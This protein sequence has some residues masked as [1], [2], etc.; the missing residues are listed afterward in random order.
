ASPGP[1]GTEIILLSCPTRKQGRPAAAPGRIGPH[2]ADRTAVSPHNDTERA[3]LSARLPIAPFCRGPIQHRRAHSAGHFL[4][5]RKIAPP[6][7][8]GSGRPAPY[9]VFM[10]ASIVGILAVLRRNLLA[11]SPVTVRTVITTVRRPI[12]PVDGVTL[13]RCQ[14]REHLGARVR[15]ATCGVRA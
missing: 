8:C 3:W 9:R 5:Q 12:R 10:N 15:P 4:N 7:Q 14:S 1:A 11:I 2:L 13:R 6:G